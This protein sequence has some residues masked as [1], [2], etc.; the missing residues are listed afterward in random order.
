MLQI[1]PGTSLD[2]LHD[3][4]Y[5]TGSRRNALEML[6]QGVRGGDS[7][8]LLTG[9]SGVGKSAVLHAMIAALADEPV[10]I[11]HLSNIFELAREHGALRWG[12]RVLIHQIIDRDPTDTLADCEVEA[13]LAGLMA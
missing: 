13:A 12:L 10:R 2:R 7:L 6:L 1:L 9:V 11:I 8:L 5:L 3:E 4:L